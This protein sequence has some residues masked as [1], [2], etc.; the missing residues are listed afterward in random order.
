[1]FE[2]YFVFKKVK[3]IDMYVAYLRGLYLGP[4]CLDIDPHVPVNK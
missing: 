4:S 3:S 2:L 1:M